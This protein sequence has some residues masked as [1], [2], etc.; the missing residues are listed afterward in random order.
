MAVT[1]G[2]ARR[3]ELLG[4]LV[5]GHSVLVRWR[6]TVGV[7]EVEVAGVETGAAR[8][9]GGPV[10]LRVTEL[11]RSGAW[12]DAVAAAARALWRS[13]GRVDELELPAVELDVAGGL[14]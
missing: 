6:P 1:D 8:V 9:L 7:L 5:D 10:A 11:A 13:G 14:F 4:E 3:W 12:P 2:R